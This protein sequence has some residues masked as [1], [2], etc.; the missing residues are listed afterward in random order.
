[1]GAPRTRSAAEI[2]VDELVRRMCA[3]DTEHASAEGALVDFARRL[4]PVRSSP[5]VQAVSETGRTDP[6]PTQPFGTAILTQSIDEAPV[7]PSEGET[8]SVEAKQASELADVYSH[9]PN[10]F[11]SGNWKLTVSALAL[12]ALAGVAM[13]G[14]TFALKGGVPALPKA[15]PVI[16]AAQWPTT[17]EQPPSDQIVVPSGDAGGTLNDSTQPAE[18]KL[19]SSAGDDLSAQSLRSN[20][21]A[22]AA[23]VLAAASAAETPTGVSSGT[24]VTATVNTQIMAAPVA[25]PPSTTA[26]FPDPKI[27]RAV[28]SGPE[29]TP[30]ATASASATFSD[31]AASD[32]PKPPA[33]PGRKVERET[34]GTAQPSNGKRDLPMKL[35][36]KNSAGVVVA[37]TNTTAP[38]A[39]VG[40]PS[41][42]AAKALNAA[43]TLTEPQVAP[44][45]PPALS[46]QPVNP[47]VRA[48]G[49]LV[50]ARAAPV[51]SALQTL[52]ATTA[53][54]SNGWAVQLAAPKSEPGAK[55]D[56]A[57]LS[58]K[59]A[60]ALNG[61]AIRVHKAQ[62][63]GA[64]VY[65]LRV[66]G[67]SKAD[68]AALCMRLRGD[69]SDCFIAK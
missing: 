54:P 2:N 32:A 22:Q 64:T 45:E 5:H 10:E 6:E 57:R 69:G 62:V 40:S 53:N 36:G 17:K 29:G 51:A 21:S 23:L 19:V 66:V 12:L 24:P 16:V 43:R 1:M 61:A 25:D 26:Q 60:S 30:I 7:D 34:A 33:K 44:P 65:R 20:L 11:R 48:V 50:G 41:Q 59:F 46:E 13:I 56:A 15:P 58:A 35:L 28:S 38:G 37:S 47:L 67:L 63:N 39:V 14:G 68:A 3:T 18:V 27:P 31:G 55:N 9:D 52:D 8:I 42:P 49:E 4:A